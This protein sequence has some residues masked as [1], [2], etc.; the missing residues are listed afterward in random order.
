MTLTAEQLE[1]RRGKIT[2]SIA[3]AALGLSKQKSPIEAWLEVLGESSFSGNKAT[4]RGD[5]LEGLCLDSVA[6]DL[7]LNRRPAPFRTKAD[8]AGDSTDALYYLGSDL[9]AIGE[10]KSAGLGVADEYGEEGTDEVPES[11]LIQSHWHLIHW[12][13]VDICHVPVIVG[14]FTF[15]F[16]R[17]EV[18]RDDE[19][20]G[21]LWQDLEKWHRDYVVT[22]IAPPPT[23]RDGDEKYLRGK[24]ARHI[25][26]RFIPAT[27]TIRELAKRKIEATARLKDAERE[28][29]EIKNLLRAQL[30]E[31]EGC[32][33]EWGKILNRNSA[34]R[35][36]VNW[37]AVA[38]DAMACIDQGAAR[39][40]IEKH[41]TTQPG[42][43]TLRVTYK[44]VLQ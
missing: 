12:P 15:E 31:A 5:R 9:I 38:R 42:P 40:L 24:F 4:Q 16:R 28:E 17:Y 43:R 26:N 20:E 25:E 2:S 36:K 3:A 35:T 6:E 8:W 21:I 23:H 30:G 18:H 44:E 14:G 27:E 19:L 13:E 34:D 32:V 11:T 29:K 22:K 33:A 10:G 1:K 41:T 39:S 7:G 37:E